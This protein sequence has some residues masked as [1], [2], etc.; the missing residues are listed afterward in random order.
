MGCES[1]DQVRLH[2]G[3]LLQGQIRVTKLKSAF[4][5]FI[6]DFSTITTWT[7]EGEID[8]F[9]NMLNQFPDGSV[10]KI[11]SLHVIFSNF[12]I[13]EDLFSHKLSG[14]LMLLKNIGQ[15]MAS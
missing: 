7:K 10:G 14:V 6:S 5:L 13:R 3:P 11:K 2:L 9:R 15:M 12:V 8:G 1:F 4:S